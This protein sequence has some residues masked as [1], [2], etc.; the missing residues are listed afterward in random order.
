[1]KKMHFLFLC[2]DKRV[3]T[4]LR[5]LLNERLFGSDKKRSRREDDNADTWTNADSVGNNV[6]V[7]SS[8]IGMRA[9]TRQTTRVVPVSKT[10]LFALFFLF[11][12][13]FFFLVVW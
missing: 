3:R 11:F 8:I 4:A 10:N 6:S 2:Q 1:M 5:R 13:F 7:T 12:F 9:G